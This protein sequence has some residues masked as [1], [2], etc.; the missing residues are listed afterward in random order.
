ML[1]YVYF[2]WHLFLILA[3][4]KKRNEQTKKQKEQKIGK[5]FICEILTFFRTDWKKHDFFHLLSSLCFLSFSF[6]P[7][8]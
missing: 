7:Q 5:N 8:K 2:K 4:H 1:N 6:L 3:C